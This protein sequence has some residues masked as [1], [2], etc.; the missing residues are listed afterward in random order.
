MIFQMQTI[1]KLVTLNHIVSV[2]SWNGSP[3]DLLLGVTY[4]SVP[5]CSAT[6]FNHREPYDRDRVA[7]FGI[8]A[9]CSLRRTFLFY[10]STGQGIFRKRYHRMF[11]EHIRFVMKPL[12]PDY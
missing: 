12:V 6:E 1:M 9:D 4:Q 3:K 2:L 5:P 11:W 8:L 10:F 7:Y